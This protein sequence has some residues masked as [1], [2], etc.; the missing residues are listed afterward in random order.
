L[1][2]FESSFEYMRLITLILGL[3]LAFISGVYANKDSTGVKNIKGKIFVLHQVEKGQGL[4]GIAKRYGTTVEK[5]KEANKDLGSS[6]S[7]GQVIMV[8]YG[9]KVNTPEVIE[10]K[11][12]KKT[13][14]KTEK[15]KQK[16]EKQPEDKNGTPI[17]HVVVKKET[18]YQIAVNHKITIEQI[19]TWNKIDNGGLKA[20]Q[21][22]IVGYHAKEEPRA[23]KKSKSK[24]DK[25]S[26]NKGKVKKTT[27][28]DGDFEDNTP[29]NTVK[30]E[31]RESGMATWVDDGSITTE[32]H[33]AMH[34]N[35]PVGTLIK[36]T[37][38]MNGRYKYVKVVANLP[39]NDENNNILIK[40][41]KNTA[42]ELDIRDKAF[43]VDLSYS[44]DVKK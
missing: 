17:Y 28:P 38:P 34:K 20:G 40:I 11:P 27:K 36:V 21:K 24:N 39:Q 7:V 9:R 13:P 19:K 2:K 18:L 30:K 6:L 31:I 10:H 23:E 1:D 41:G 32:V 16:T 26:N 15:T 25:N 29:V 3:Q 35:A 4:Y 43:R 42:D 12:A 22:I 37:N 5:I 14:E 33:L 44:I 8:P